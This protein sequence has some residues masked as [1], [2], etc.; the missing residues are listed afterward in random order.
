MK[1][2]EKIK[3]YEKLSTATIELEKSINSQ[4]E[5]RK[6]LY[7]GEYYTVLYLNLDSGGGSYPHLYLVGSGKDNQGRRQVVGLREI[8]ELDLE[9]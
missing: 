4:V 2:N 8:I 6:V 5:G 9:F 7:Q 1:L 3:E